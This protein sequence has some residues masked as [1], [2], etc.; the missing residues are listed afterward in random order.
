MIINCPDDFNTTTELGASGRI[1]TWQEPTFFDESGNVTLLYKT[2]DSGD[3]FP[4][5]LTKVMYLITD[6]SN[7]LAICS[8]NI[9]VNPG[10]YIQNLNLICI[11]IIF[12]KQISN[13]EDKT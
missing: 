13:N 10:E 9:Y 12:F 4:E 1:I 7:N 3:R 11:S 6:S 5:G 8:F 2:Y